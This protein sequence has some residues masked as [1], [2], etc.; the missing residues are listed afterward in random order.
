MDTAAQGVT[1]CT[2]AGTEPPCKQSHPDGREDSRKGQGPNTERTI[3]APRSLHP[4][5]ATQRPQ[6][7]STS[8]RPNSCSVPR[9]QR[10]VQKPISRAVTQHGRLPAG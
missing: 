9:A 7:R 6:G 8:A 3:Q 2:G 5:S 4:P 10:S 1:T